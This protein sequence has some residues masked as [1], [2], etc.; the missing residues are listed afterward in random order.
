GTYTDYIEVSFSPLAGNYAPGKGKGQLEVIQAQTVLAVKNVTAVYGSKDT[1]KATL[2][3][4]ELPVSGKT[5]EFLLNGKPVGT[6]VTDTKGFAFKPDVDLSAINVGQHP[7]YLGAG[8]AG[9]ESYLGS[10]NTA[11]LTITKAS[12]AVSVLP[13]EVQ[14]S[15]QVTLTAV[16]TSPAAQPGLNTS[17]GS[18]VFKYQLGDGAETFLGSVSSSTVSEGRLTFS[19]NFNCML[20]PKTY[21]I[22]AYFTPTDQVNFNDSFN[23][24]PYGPLLVN[25]EDAT[26][27]YTGLT[28]FSTASPT[29]MNVT[30][31]YSATIT[32]FPDDSR[33]NI[34]NAR[35]DFIEDPEEGIFDKKLEGGT[36]LPVF[37]VD[38]AVQTVGTSSTQPV[39]RNVSSSTFNKLGA[40]FNVY[41]KVRGNYSKLSDPT[42]ITIGIPG[43]DNISGGGFITSTH[44]AGKYHG[45]AGSKANFGFT[46]KYNKSGKN[47]QGQANII[48]R[49]EDD[50]MYQIKSN[51]VNSMS[52]YTIKGLPGK[53]ASFDTKANLTDITDPLYPV[54]LGGSLS[55]T[56]EMYDGLDDKEN[57]A[58]AITL[59]DPGTS[60]DPG[61]GLLYSSNWSGTKTILTSLGAP[62]GGGNI[63]VLS[64]SGLAKGM[65]EEMI[66]KEY[67]LYQ[68]FPNPFNPSTNIQF[69]LPEDSR[70]KIVIYNIL[71]GEVAT[72]INDELPAGK[73]QA[74]WNSQDGGGQSASGMYIMRITAKSL[75]SQRNLVSTKKMMLV[76]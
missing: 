47:N 8:F 38:P 66:P 68:N 62:N 16:V 74:V 65:S 20:D 70:V 40:T 67:A 35:V 45:K 23:A 27:E 34:T 36:N 52:V 37:L 64:S 73:H 6:A 54:A 43:N 14:Y 30:L 28:Y 5:I 42:L 32:D 55:L 15:D 19:Y 46:M 75:T 48:I 13:S 33:G 29:S 41:T 2:T 57:D 58:I 3:S 61:S 24:S 17:G 22:H 1:L 44:S 18:V 72:L 25:H 39:S 71:G 21:K 9:D 4:L 56:V 63:K 11:D 53:A 51:A 10:N 60:K 49:G 50:K 69:D 76:K 12:T 26:A 31:T 7:A 59:Q